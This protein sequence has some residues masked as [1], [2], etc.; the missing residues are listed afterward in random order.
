MG[1]SGNLKAPEF[2]LPVTFFSDFK[3]EIFATFYYLFFYKLDISKYTPTRRGE[4]FLLQPEG[5]AKA[6]TKGPEIYIHHRERSFVLH[7]VKSK[8]FFFTE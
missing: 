3:R 1:R 5:I 7:L 2:P 8:N 4:F 6:V